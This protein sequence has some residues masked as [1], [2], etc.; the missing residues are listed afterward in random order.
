MK[1][2]FCILISLIG[3]SILVYLP[4]CFDDYLWWKADNK[5]SI[6]YTDKYD[7]VEISTKNLPLFTFK[8][9]LQFVNVNPEAWYFLDKSNDDEI[10]AP[11]HIDRINN[12]N[13]K[14]WNGRLLNPMITVANPIFFKSFFDWCKY[15]HWCKKMMKEKEEYNNNQEK[16]ENIERFCAAMQRDIDAARVELEKAVAATE[17]TI[18]AQSTI[19]QPT[20]DGL[21]EIAKVAKAGLK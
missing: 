13:C 21:N 20:I 15:V 2:F 7:K 1:V 3:I 12:P 5:C 17:R 10:V 16:K 6:R 4:H 8:Q 14:V 19:A 9:F 18:Q 11:C